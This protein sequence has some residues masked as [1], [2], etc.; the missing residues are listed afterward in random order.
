MSYTEFGYEK[1]MK[2]QHTYDEYIEI[3]DSYIFQN[4]PNHKC[5]IFAESKRDW[6]ILFNLVRKSKN[7]HKEFAKIDNSYAGITDHAISVEYIKEDVPG[8]F[9]R[10]LS[11]CSLLWYT[12]EYEYRDF[13]VVPFSEVFGNAI[14]ISDI[15]DSELESMFD[16][17][18][19]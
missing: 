1:G 8:A 12:S 19:Q 13:T 15:A 9:R 11:W 10:Y 16:I 5:L 7:F 6:L 4:I 2:I 14:Q 18:P 17:S 3:M